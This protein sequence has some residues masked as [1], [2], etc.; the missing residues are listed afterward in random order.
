MTDESTTTARTTADRCGAEGEGCGVCG[1]CGRRM[2][3]HDALLHSEATTGCVD[4]EAGSEAGR[5]CR[6]CSAT[7]QHVDHGGICAACEVELFRRE[8]L[9]AAAADE[10]TTDQVVEIFNM[11]Q[12]ASTLQGKRSFNEYE[13]HAVD[14]QDATKIRASLRRIFPFHVGETGSLLHVETT[15]NED[16]GDQGWNFAEHVAL[17]PCVRS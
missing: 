16:L 9:E 17:M 10:S 12:I 3:E 4:C 14:C 13:V 6:E 15:F 2:E 8:I 5:P 7:M 11:D 1:P